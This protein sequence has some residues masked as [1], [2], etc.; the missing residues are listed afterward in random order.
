MTQSIATTT[1]AATMKYYVSVTGLQVKSMWHMPRFIYY[2]SQINA[3]SF[4][5]NIDQQFTGRNG[6]QHTLTVWNDRKSM[7]KFYASGPHAAAMKVT[8]QIATPGGTKVYGYYSNSIP[9]WDEALVLWDEHGAMHGRKPTR[10]TST[11]TASVPE[12]N[13]K[14]RMGS[15]N[16]DSSNGNGGSSS[17]SSTRV[18]K[19]MIGIGS[20]LGVISVLTVIL[21]FILQPEWIQQ[22]SATVNQ[23]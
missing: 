11:T 20:S 5:G 23:I 14:K 21:C 10:T 9:T 6:V 15:G 19:R 12:T 17:M 13:Q 3:S 18:A 22:T 1:T 8:S 4:P 16:S 2:V 7:M